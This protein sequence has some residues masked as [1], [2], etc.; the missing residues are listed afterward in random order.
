[1]GRLRGARE[2]IV[3]LSITCGF[4]VVIA[5]LLS[6]DQMQLRGLG[7]DTVIRIGRRLFGTYRSALFLYEIPLIGLLLSQLILYLLPDFWGM[8]NYYT[9]E[10]VAE[11]VSFF[12]VALL[13]LP[14]CTLIIVW[15]RF[16]MPSR[17]QQAGS[18]T[19]RRLQSRNFENALDMAHG[20]SAFDDIMDRAFK[21]FEGRKSPR[22][23]GEVYRDY[24]RSRESL[25]TRDDEVG[26]AFRQRLSQWNEERR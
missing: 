25:M 19:G 18:Q 5:V 20:T 15:G 23:G 8:Y 22:F 21:N 6:I 12:L 11:S 2:L 9:P 10:Q 24:L 16:R 4:L 7:P 26:V 17:P 3:I 13:I 1:M 14:S